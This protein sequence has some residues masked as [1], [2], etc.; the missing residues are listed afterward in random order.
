MKKIILPIFCALFLVTLSVSVVLA[1]DGDSGGSSGGSSSG[2]GS[3]GSSGSSDRKSDSINTS[4]GS[5]TGG[6]RP[7]DT[8]SLLD[9]QEKER[10]A[11]KK[12]FEKENEAAKHKFEQ[13]RE[14]KIE[15]FKN[16]REDL[17]KKL[18]QEK[19]DL[20]DKRFEK[21]VTRFEK[22]TGA[23]REALARLDLIVSKIQSRIDKLKASGADVSA[24]QAALTA[25][26]SVKS[27]AAAAI[28]NSEAQVSTIDFNSANAKD[29]A[30][31]Q[32]AAIK[33]SNQALKSYH[34]CL[35]DVISKAP[36]SDGKG[37]TGSA[38]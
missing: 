15:E 33:Q 29:I 17:H 12:G 32:V 7:P 2:S 11:A 6:I 37:A 9:V 31:T 30:Q 10:E 22:I 13:E 23:R 18:E 35:K 19:K 24:M 1:K 26:G 8:R 20:K 38:Q 3:S 36:K 27:T 5:N 16:K 34:T 21:V 4:S 25:C 14:K 28:T